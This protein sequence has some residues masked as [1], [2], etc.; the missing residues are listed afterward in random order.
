MDKLNKIVLPK[1]SQFVPAVF[2]ALHIA[3][4]PYDIKDQ[5][6]DIEIDIMGDLFPERAFKLGVLTGKMIEVVTECACDYAKGKYNPA[7][8]DP[9]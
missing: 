2:L 4:V 7:I 8:P 9:E 1:K 6:F 5:G 3:E